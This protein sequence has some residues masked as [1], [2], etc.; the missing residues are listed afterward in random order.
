MRLTLI[1]HAA[2]AATRAAAF[3]LD[4][5]I[6]EPGAAAAA[7]AKLQTAD[8]VWT[9]PALRARQ[10]A[11]ALGLEAAVEPLL[12]DADCGRWAGRRLAALQGEEPDAVAAWLS[13]PSAAPHGGESVLDVLRRVGAW[14]DGLTAARS[15]AIAV[16]HPAV[17]RAAIAHVLGAPPPSFWRI[18]VEPLSLTD[19]RRG[20]R[21]WTLRAA[22]VPL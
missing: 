1:C 8:R 13:D 10:T 7:A 21:H 16:T 14:L 2:T 15:R 12:R 17:V 19:L 11:S 20:P 4:E 18:D 5:P 3:P 6:D 9:S 22:G